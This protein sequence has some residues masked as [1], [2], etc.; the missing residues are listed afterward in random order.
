MAK[1]KKVSRNVDP[2]S[3]LP[4]ASTG[5]LAARA[6]KESSRQIGLDLAVEDIIKIDHD[7]FAIARA[8]QRK[9]WAKEKR[10][11]A[12]A[13]KMDADART[14][15]AAAAAEEEAAAAAAREAQAQKEV[16]EARGR[17]AQATTESDGGGGGSKDNQ[18]SPGGR[19]DEN[20]DRF[21]EEEDKEGSAPGG[22]GRVGGAPVAMMGS[23]VDDYDIE[24]FFAEAEQGQATS[25]ATEDAELGVPFAV[26][27]D[28]QSRAPPSTESGIGMFDYSAALDKISA[29]TLDSVGPTGTG[30][31]V[32]TF[33]WPDEEKLLE[34]GLDDSTRREVATAQGGVEGD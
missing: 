5:R 22:G 7:D 6:K 17:E 16:A 11:A 33:S 31:N 24:A 12:R 10:D 25:P 30:T 29:I 28:D 34:K 3:L 18:V 4:S 23:L 14:A 13:V 32:G 19:D 8:R 15:E 26:V 21:W 2:R 27:P 20:I 1:V 9:K